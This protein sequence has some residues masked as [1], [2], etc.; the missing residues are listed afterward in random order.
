[1]SDQSDQFNKALPV[2]GSV[3]VSLCVGYK[4]ANPLSVSTLAVIGLV[5]MVLCSPIFL[6]WHY[7]LLVLSWS[8]GLQVFFLP[9]TPPLWMLMTAVSLAITLGTLILRPDF[10]VNVVPSITWTLAAL[11]LIVVVTA[12]L[13]GGVGLRSMGGSSYGGKKYVFLVAAVFGFVALSSWRIPPSKRRLYAAL[14][15]LGSLSLVLPNLAYFL[16]PKFYWLYSFLPAEFAV[17]QAMADIEPNT[18]VRYNG[19]GVAMIGVFYFM[20]IQWGI[21]GVLDWRK[22][23]RFATV[24]LIV[25]VSLL[26]GFR[27]IV[28]LYLL[29]FGIMFFLEKMWRPFQMVYLGVFGTFAAILVVIFIDRMPLS[30]QRS[31]SF[32]PLNI[33]PSVRA[34][35]SHSSNWR[36]MMWN[37]V[38]QEVPNFLVIGKGYGI[39]P[40]DLYMAK[41]GVRR[42]YM[43]SYEISLVAGDYHSGPLS[44]LLIFGIPGCLA[45]IGFWA[46]ALRLLNS[47]RI[48]GPPELRRF[49]NFL[50]ALF[51]ARIL[52]F[53]IVFGDLASDMM[54]FTGIAG[55]SIA[56][57]GGMLRGPAETPE[58]EPEPEEAMESAGSELQPA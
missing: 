27:S 6:R 8:V 56:L 3:L 25:G 49:N 34:D 14:Y 42:G 4:L 54:I 28:A 36:F 46:M 16:G 17:G 43:K 30:V 11:L 19:V 21:G 5:L 44:I 20:V 47:N 15:T 7:P 55:V 38:W 18:M 45:V 10:R 53:I 40:T 24:L 9:G 37:L 13:R 22:P 33:D 1:M 39:N 52:F 50:F 26:G 32:L 35:A 12:A 23:W 31:L 48:H 57:N 2:V 41:E 58:A 51:V 29:I